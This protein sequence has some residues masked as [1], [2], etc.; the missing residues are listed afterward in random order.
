[1]KT[2]AACGMPLVKKEDFAGGDETSQFCLHCVNSDG[3]VKSCEEIF[4]GGVA[5][6]L[7]TLGGEKSMAEKITRMQIYQMLLEVDLTPVPLGCAHLIKAY[8]DIIC[9]AKACNHCVHRQTIKPQITAK[10]SIHVRKK[11]MLGPRHSI[12]ILYKR[13]L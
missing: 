2:C 8:D 1:M 6:F 5:F 3:S 10:L 12:Y 9:P 4:N 7:Q 11:P 13:P